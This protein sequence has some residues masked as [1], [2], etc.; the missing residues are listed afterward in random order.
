[1]EMFEEEKTT[2]EGQISNH[3]MTIAA[4]LEHM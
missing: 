2:Y 1:M 3:Q 4:L